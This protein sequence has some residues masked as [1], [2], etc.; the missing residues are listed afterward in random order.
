M[1]LA[2]DLQSNHNPKVLPGYWGYW[3]SQDNC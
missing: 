1:P 2:Q 3:G